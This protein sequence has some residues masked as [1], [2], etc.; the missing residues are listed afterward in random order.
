[1][2]KTTPVCLFF[3]LCG[4]AVTAQPYYSWQKPHAQVLAT[5]DLKWK[6]EPFVFNKGASLRYVDFAT[7]KDDNL[8]SSKNAPWKHHPWDPKATG[9]AAAC[10]GIHTYVFKRGVTYRGS[11]VAKEAGQL[12]NPIRL[13]S[14]P[15]WGAGEA[16][17]SGA[18]TVGGWKK[19]ATHKNIP[20]AG[21]VWW[22]DLNY[23]PRCVWVVDPQGKVTNVPIARTPNWKVSDPEDVMSEW[24]VLQ[25]PQ[26]W[27]QAKHQVKVG[28]TLMH[29]GTDAKHL[30]KSA[31]YYVGAKIWSEW[32]IVMGTPFPS[33]V[34]GYDGG[35]KAVAYQGMWFGA[36]GRSITGNRYFLED[37][38]HYLD[39]AGEHWFEKK[40]AGG[41]LFIRLPDDADP[42]RARVEAAKRYSIIEDVCSAKAPNRLDVLGS[43]ANDPKTVPTH[44]VE[45]L[46]ISGLSFCFNNIWWNTEYAV[47]MHKEIDSAAIRLRGSCD[48]VR[49]ANCRFEHV[50]EAVQVLPINK[51][52]HSGSFA[53]T[54]NFISYTGDDAINVAK[55]G[56]SIQNVDFLRNKLFMIGMRP[57]RQSSGHAVTIGYP[58]TME[59][60][61]NILNRTYGAGLFLFGGKPNGSDRDAPLGRYL[62]HHN[63]VEQ[64]LLA[65]NDW[66]GIETWQG[67]PFYVYNNISANPGGLWWPGDR[68][69]FAYY[70]DGG[71]K[72]Y[73]FNNI[74][75]GANNKDKKLANAF[76]F[77]E[78][79]GT[80]HN[81]FMNNTI[82]RFK[83]GSSWSP[84]GGHHHY[85]GNLWSDISRGVYN[86]GKLKEDAK[87][88]TVRYPYGTMAYG[89]DVFHRIEKFGNFEN[90]LPKKEA[91]HQ[92]FA[93][94]EAAVKRNKTLNSSLGTSTN[95]NPMRDPANRDMRLTS[96]SAAIDK[97]VT[98]FV[99]WGLYGMVGEWNFYHHGNDVGK[100]PDQH[101]YMAEYLNNRG[102]YH[103]A[104]QFPLRV[105]NV[106][107]SNY[108]SG[109]LEN[110]V[111]GALQL[112]GKNQYAV[113]THAD[114]NKPYNY[115]VDKQK[116]T[117]SGDK[118]KNPE[119]HTSNF[120]IE[121][122]F[123]SAVGQGR[124]ILIE[125]MGRAG[126]SLTLNAKGGV[127]LTVKERDREVKLESAL[128]VN[129]ARW[130]HVIAEADRQA[131]TMTIYLD[132]R[133]NVVGRGL[134]S[135]SLANSADLHIGGSPKGN[136]LNGA[137]EFVRI[138]QGTLKDA[139]TTI[140]ELFHWQF[141]GPQHHDFTGRKPTGLHRDAGALE[142]VR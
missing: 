135:E 76:A 27:E 115:T 31:D 82:Y 20:D 129:D 102:S 79:V 87:P 61:G 59:V 44:G 57:N 80:I 140:E 26:W 123:K 132:G 16:V 78:A 90:H 55:G 72:N 32:G 116:K 29:R 92:D 91:V 2:K 75:C 12:G 106:T 68:L 93:S 53:I 65:A 58:V 45:H 97:G 46:E 109:P 60:A 4:F 35:R 21:K 15:S 64:T 62:V 111:K 22:A 100:I 63:R 41:R 85:A 9:K 99:P 130:H 3:V 43:R 14:D 47:W 81:S 24:W 101:W 136:Y 114:M 126:Y 42:N 71:F 98:H 8:G 49:I 139:R 141:H 17:L 38:P 19:G 124:S 10:K 118:L 83:S 36:S 128:K 105:V 121:I 104:P 120:L 56:G 30:T 13:T 137:I 96:D 94:M 23:S 34:E 11:L 39:S 108:V 127:T 88:S 73:L 142:F 33:L 86:H 107:E 138:C 113:L 112:N 7:G 48:N 66:G 125:K 103:E 25:Q 122:C 134:G 110:W 18:E 69:G 52:A 89:P 67:G 50:V 77:Y 40:G 6:P 95:S 54:D 133:K 51:H 74:A 117:V 84:R 37:K 119:I 28:R 131:K 5:G 70:L 1:V